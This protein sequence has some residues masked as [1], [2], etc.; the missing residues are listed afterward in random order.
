MKKYLTLLLLIVHYCGFSQINSI[1]SDIILQ[2]TIWSSDTIKINNDI[3]VASN[4]VLSINPGVYVEFQ[5]NYSLDVYGKIL[6]LGTEIDS[7][8]FTI[9]DT[10][11]FADTATYNGGWG[12]IKLLKN[13]VDTSIFQYCN[14]SY[15]KA[16]EIGVYAG[17]SDNENL[18]GGAIYSY[19][20][21]KLFINNCYFNNNHATFQGGAIYLYDADVAVVSD[22]KFE[23]NFTY[24]RGGGLSA[25]SNN[26]IKISEN[27]FISN[28]AYRINYTVWGPFI[29][30]SGAGIHTSVNE[31]I[32]II[33]NNKYFNNKC[34]NGAIYESNKNTIV[35]NNIVANNYG[36]GLL[37]GHSYGNQKY[38]NNT[39]CYNWLGGSVAGLMY[40]NTD[41][42]LKGNIFWG[43]ENDP[44]Y[45]VRQEIQCP[46]CYGQAIASYND[47]KI[48]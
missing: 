48:E 5:G 44:Y 35:T 14:F 38:T 3:M 40:F 28:I 23:N 43:N 45:P 41:L 19:K 37:S 34:V 29:S 4:V 1:Y 33:N 2:D 12:S 11:G 17:S 32:A 42:E 24:Y 21:S 13:S 22:N 30:G 10:T 36:M 18:K 26:N 39:V 47:M 25:I 31:Q 6:A 7:I 9:N 27:S 20:H 16:N 15:G 46:G 8:Y